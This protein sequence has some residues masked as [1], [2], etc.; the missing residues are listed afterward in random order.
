[1]KGAWSCL[2]WIWIAAPAA[3]GPL[4]EPVSFQT[5][6]FPPLSAFLAGAARPQAGLSLGPP[7]DAAQRLAA[8]VVVESPAGE[9]IGPGALLDKLRAYNLVFVG[10]QHDQA[11]HHAV[12]LEM[13]R[14]LHKARPGLQLGLEMLDYAKQPLL[15]RYLSG[16]MSEAEFAELWERAWGFDFRLYR[17]ILIF[18]RDNGIGVRAL[19]APPEIVRQVA[20]GGLSSLS[21]EARA[22]LP[23]TIAPIRHPKYLAFVR[24][25]LNEH[26]PLDPVREARMLEAMAVWNETMAESALRAASSGPLLVIAGSGHMLFRAGILE[27]VANRAHVSQGVV[28]PYPLD[29]VEGPVED[30]L[31]RL[32]DPASG[33]L[34]QADYFWLLPA[35]AGGVP[36]A[37]RSLSSSL[38]GGALH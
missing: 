9:L 1:M 29:G 16:A 19:N 11:S 21:P 8:P 32:R 13:F 30:L 3:A 35:P 6:S 20:R 14:T 2:A 38:L 34:E 28:L 17:E 25:S 22:A 24:K 15:D 26:G 12:Q 37:A 27:S 36:Q 33:E 10:E 5:V 4:E 18:A 7:L 31:R 23:A